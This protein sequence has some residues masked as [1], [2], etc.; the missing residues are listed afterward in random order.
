MSRKCWDSSA[1][2]FGPHQNSLTYPHLQMGE[3]PAAKWI[4]QVAR[5]IPREIREAEA[6]VSRRIIMRNNCMHGALW[7]SMP[8]WILR[9]SAG[10]PRANNTSGAAKPPGDQ[11]SLSAVQTELVGLAIQGYLSLQPTEQPHHL[12]S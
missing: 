7:E 4:T 9:D 10:D 6:K 1:V 8:C 5:M 3:R 2:P 12:P 11:G